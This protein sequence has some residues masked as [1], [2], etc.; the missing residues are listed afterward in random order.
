[1]I[2]SL[3]S[4]L[5]HNTTT[6]PDETLREHQRRLLKFLQK[7]FNLEEGD[8]YSAGPE[9]GAGPGGMADEAW[10]AGGLLRWVMVVWDGI[11]DGI[12]FDG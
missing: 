9:P 2:S 4:A 11:D 5:N 12:G 8:Y 6:R 7:K 10:Y 1:V 3:F